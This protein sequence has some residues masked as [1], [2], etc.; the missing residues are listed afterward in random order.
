[1]EEYTA[2]IHATTHIMQKKVTIKINNED[3]RCVLLYAEQ[4]LL[5]MWYSNRLLSNESRSVLGNVLLVHEH[6]DW[7]EETVLSVHRVGV[8]M[9]GEENCSEL[10]HNV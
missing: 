7:P 4:S 6:K 10:A 5:P 2:Q 3:M 1:M 9:Q 8:M